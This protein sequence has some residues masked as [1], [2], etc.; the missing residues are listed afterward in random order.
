MNHESLDYS[1]SQAFIQAKKDAVALMAQAHD[2]F[3]DENHILEVASSVHDIYD[4]LPEYEKK[5]VDLEGVELAALYHDT[6]RIRI[7]ANLLMVPFF[8]E[9]YSGDIAASSLPKV[10]Y[11]SERAEEVKGIIRGHAKI[12][13]IGRH[14]NINS[15]ILS[16]A[17]KLQVYNPERFERGLVR[18]E[19][20]M[21]PKHLLN[22]TVIA[23][24]TMRNKIPKLIHFSKSKELQERYYEELKQYLKANRSRLDKLLYKPI[25]KRL[26]KSFQI[27]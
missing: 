18:F 5:S 9:K 20:E 22:I 7:G 21:F 4:S 11:S 10:G 13:G 17:D 25:S 26:Y 16:D 3:H 24:L 2:P 19:A 27:S 15:Q 6:S 14:D 23:L 8:D 12:G 1:Q